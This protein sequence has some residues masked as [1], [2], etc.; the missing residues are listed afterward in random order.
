MEDLSILR[1]S[2][3][4]KTLWKKHLKIDP[5]DGLVPQLRMSRRFW[6]ARGWVIALAPWLKN[7]AS[8]CIRTVLPKAIRTRL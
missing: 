6:G 8:L 3:P 1:G 4:L 2:L 5:V 7:L